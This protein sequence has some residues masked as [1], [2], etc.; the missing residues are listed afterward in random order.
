MS[1]SRAVVRLIRL[2]DVLLIA[3]LVVAGGAVATRAVSAPVLLAAISTACIAAGGYA[4]ND[5]CDVEIDR[6]NKPYRPLPAGVLVRPQALAFSVLLQAVGVGVSLLLNLAAMGLIGVATA[7]VNLYSLRL[8]RFP[9]AGNVTTAGLLT[10]AFIVGGVAGD[11]R[12]E[13]QTLPLVIFLANLA[14]EMIK[15]VEDIPG[16]R[17]YQ[18]R[19]LAVLWGPRWMAVGASSLFLGAAALLFDPRL[20]DAFHASYLWLNTLVVTPMSLILALRLIASQGSAAAW[21]R[22]WSKVVLGAMLAA[23]ICGMVRGNGATALVF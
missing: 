20:I 13:F 15:D 23:V 21:A 4:V 19:T 6:I 18:V 9:L 3:V 1:R 5:W 8:R 2:E 11:A 10:L 16:D 17:Q 7:L 14:R 12:L 22:G